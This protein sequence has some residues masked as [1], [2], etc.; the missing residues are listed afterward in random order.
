MVKSKLTIAVKTRLVFC[1]LPDRLLVAAPMGGLLKRNFLDQRGVV[2][3]CSRAIHPLRHWPPLQLGAAEKARPSS[4]QA[5]PAIMSGSIHFRLTPQA[6][7]QEG[8]KRWRVGNRPFAPPRVLSRRSP[9]MLV[10]GW[11]RS[12]L[13][14]IGTASGWQWR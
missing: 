7:A 12:L 6:K 10:V 14:S 1:E 5:G 13:V 2:I 3:W 11:L 8:S 4:G 9:A